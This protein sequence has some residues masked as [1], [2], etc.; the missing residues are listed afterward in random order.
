MKSC[1]F[2][3]VMYMRVTA[4]IKVPMVNGVPIFI[5]LSDPFYRPSRYDPKVP[6]DSDEGCDL[7]YHEHFLSILTEYNWRKAARAGV[8]PIES[9][10]ADVPLDNNKICSFRCRLTLKQRYRDGPSRY[11]PTPNPWNSFR[12]LIEA[13]D[14]EEEMVSR[15]V[16]GHRCM[17]C[18]KDPRNTKKCFRSRVVSRKRMR[19]SRGVPECLESDEAPVK[20]RRLEVLT[21]T[22][23]AGSFKFEH[24]ANVPPDWLKMHYNSITT[25]EHNSFRPLAIPQQHGKSS[26]LEELDIDAGATVKVCASSLNAPSLTMELR[27]W[28]D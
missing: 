11:H 23:R 14:G 21:E 4:E 6:K 1:L 2:M 25:I 8:W 20:V 12:I 24:D 16:K 9:A 15:A 18:R 28:T 3:I 5:S 7:F 27:L 13:K 26:Q 19:I 22:S 17:G 10:R